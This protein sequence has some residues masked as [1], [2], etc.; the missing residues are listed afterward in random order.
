MSFFMSCAFGYTLLAQV[1]LFTLN[2]ARILVHR[3]CEYVTIV[4]LFVLDPS[5]FRNN[6]RSLC[7]CIY[8]DT[9]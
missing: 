7:E 9:E 2:E 1:C 8:I 6:H 5:N 4:G 3:A